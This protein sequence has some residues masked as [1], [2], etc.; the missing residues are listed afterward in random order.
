MSEGKTVSDKES[1]IRKISRELEEQSKEI[2]SYYDK[3]YDQFLKDFD[4]LEKT[5]EI[6]ATILIT[7]LYAG[8]YLAEMIKAIPSVTLTDM[9]D[10]EEDYKFLNELQLL[11]KINFLKMFSEKGDADFRKLM[12]DLIELNRNRNEIAHHF[13]IRKLKLQGKDLKITEENV[14]KLN[15]NLRELITKVHKTLYQIWGVE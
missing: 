1:A 6:R 10:E 12:Q 4:E 13:E 3:I 2:K 9:S 14:K 8:F 5:N 7:H 11:N 15:S